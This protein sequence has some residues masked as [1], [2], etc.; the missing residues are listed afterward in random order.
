[1]NKK[2]Q[3]AKILK[4]IAQLDKADTNDVMMEA[5]TTGRFDNED[6]AN[7]LWMDLRCKSTVDGS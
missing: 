2:E 1:M 4:I 7:Q 3:V 6:D 5:H